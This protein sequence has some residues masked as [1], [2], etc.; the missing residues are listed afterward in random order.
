MFRHTAQPREISPTQIGIRILQLCVLFTVPQL[1]LHA[2]V[3]ALVL[4]VLL[5]RA[6]APILIPRLAPECF[7]PPLNFGTLDTLV[8]AGANSRD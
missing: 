4:R 2:G 3:A 1:T 8:N 5:C 7:L 6:L